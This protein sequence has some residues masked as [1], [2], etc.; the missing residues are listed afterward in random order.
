MMIISYCI[1]IGVAGILTLALL[2]AKKKNS[3]AKELLTKKILP[4][5]LALIYLVRLFCYQS[6]ITDLVGLAS[7]PLS[8][9]TLTVF[10]LFFIWFYSTVILLV[11]LRG[12][13]DFKSLRNLTKWIGVPVTFVSIVLLAP[14]ILLFQGGYQTSVLSILYPF[15]L[16]VTFALAFNF[17]WED[18]KERISKK[19]IGKMLGVFAVMLIASLPS[20]FFQFMFG[21]VRGAFLIK[22]LTFTHRLF[23][24]GAILV[25]VGLYFW[26][27]NKPREVIHF[28]MIYLSVATL[29]VFLVNHNYTEL[30][31]PWEWPFHLC[32]TAMF[33]VPICVIFKRKKLFYFTYFINVMGALIAM[34]MPNYGDL[35]NLFSIRIFNFWSN[36]YIA[37][38]SPVL[39]V[40]LGEFERPKLPQFIQS[41]IGFFVYFLLALTMNVV[42]TAQGHSV[43]YFFLNTDYVADKLGSWAEQMFKLNATIHVSGL[44]LEFHPLYQI[45]FFLVYVAL[46]AG[47]WFVYGEF[48]R[49]ADAHKDLH[50]RL[51]KIKLDEIAIASSLSGRSIDE[52]MDKTCGVC[53]KLDH[54]SKQY[55]SSKKFAVSDAN[56]CVQGGEIFGF[57]GP[58]GAGKST[59]IKSTV[60]IQTITSGSIQICGY[61]VAKQ[62]VQAKSC[63]G[64]VPDHYALYEKLT[65]R[66][67]INYI[68]DIYEVSQID[69]DER[70][71]K[72]IHRFELESSIDNKIKTYSHGMKQKITIISALIHDPKVW[73][74]DEPLTGLDPNSIYQVKECMKE[75]AAK[76]NI[77]FF[78][79]HIIDIVEKL[80]GRVAIIKHG[81]IQCVKTVK[82]IEDSGTSLEQF[83][84]NVIGNN[85]E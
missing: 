44:T 12:F 64:Y 32:N 29:V 58:N 72:F 60:G 1:A 22:K 50:A 2:W 54:F 40:A 19:E 38:F 46:G 82:E 8:S 66:E 24:Y 25:P 7:T 45:C 10:C 28:S 65:G 17:L 27:R 49:I 77:V 4:I 62:A 67:Y 51:K 31:K 11:I 43:D 41:M 13:Y 80:C 34:L 39:L 68:A 57:L 55:A 73:I 21:Y 79:S 53:Y 74:L 70:L 18:K 23:L 26:L 63:I 20:Y 33:I 35:T 71:E 75:H 85:E 16:G 42:F 59:I 83:Y 84:L 9:K 76:G 15:E 14:T 5:G 69:R 37:F 48:Y 61:D 30:L 81:Q 47:V 3:K 78:S 56:L 52:P 36:H 6:K